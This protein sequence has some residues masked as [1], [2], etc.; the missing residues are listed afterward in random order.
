MQTGTDSDPRRIVRSAGYLDRPRF[1]A[2]VNFRDLGGHATERHRV[3]RHR[4]VF[5]AD[6][7]HRCTAADIATLE[8]LGVRRVID[9]RTAQERVTDGSFAAQHPTI[10]Y[11][12]V[13]ILDDVSGIGEIV[14]AEPLVVSYLHML[15]ERAA[16]LV[17]AVEAIVGAPGP[18][19][20]HCTAGK[21]RTGV[22]AALVLQTLGVPR[23]T[24]VAD[25][26]K[27]EGAMDRLIAW[28]RAHRP[29][30]DGVRDPSTDPARS[31]LMGARPE[32]MHKVLDVLDERYGGAERYLLAAGA[33][34]TTLR[35]L[36]V[37]ML[38]A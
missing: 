13:P 19:V 20:F 15:E 16:R 1:E 11:R 4:T 12:H 10:D 31:K 27:S 37:R 14:H 22:L 36:R 17:R 32:W 28:Y 3:T 18:V 35:A 2:L 8:A 29:E 26:A 34:P 23:E 38:A 30:S 24:I 25:Y 5:R 33:T 6:G 7:V 21:D 9:L